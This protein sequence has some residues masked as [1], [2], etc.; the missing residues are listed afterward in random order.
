[1][2]F[3]A[4][5]WSR[6]RRLVLL[7]LILLVVGVGLLGCGS[8][9]NRTTQ[10]ADSSKNKK[11]KRDAPARQGTVRSIR[12][13]DRDISAETIAR[14]YRIGVALSPA[15]TIYNGTD[16]VSKTAGS[17]HQLRVILRQQR[18]KRFLA[19]ASIE[20][21]F[22]DNTG[23]VLKSLDLLETFGP[24]HFY[25]K[26]L[27]IPDGA[28]ELALRVQPP[29][30]GRHADFKERFIKPVSARFPVTTTG[31]TV[32]VRGPEP[33][34]VPGDVTLGS[35]ITTSLDEAIALKTTGPYHVGY[36]AELAEPFWVF[37]TYGTNDENTAYNVRLADIPQSANRH[38]EILLFD[39]QTYRVIPHADVRLHLTSTT[40]NTEVKTPLPFLMSAFYHY[41]NS[42]Y[43]P[44][45]DYSVKATIGTPRIHSLRKGRFPK[46][47]TVTFEWTAKSRENMESHEHENDH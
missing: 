17:T 21:V 23:R 20:A 3:P 9:N 2:N 15:A 45:G 41:G 28:T 35:D 38:L 29:R 39:R 32:T 37:D 19:G 33:R 18:T 5:V 40:D 1:M 26:N 11:Q 16:P 4:T 24:Y 25:G 31:G 8:G 44:P 30:V 42:L 7:P 14:H 22:K 36:I 43:L 12:Q 6:L 34:P 46:N 13:A 27:T 10:S 47:K